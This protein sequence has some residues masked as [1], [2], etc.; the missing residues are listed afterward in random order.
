MVPQVSRRGARKVRGSAFKVRSPFGNQERRTNLE[1]RTQNSELL[2][3]LGIS[4][5]R[6]VLGSHPAGIAVPDAVPA[7]AQAVPVMVAR[8]VP[9]PRPDFRRRRVAD[10]HVL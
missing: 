3:A 4:D 8:S 9:A 5:V 1:P 10:R 6:E 2:E 7:V